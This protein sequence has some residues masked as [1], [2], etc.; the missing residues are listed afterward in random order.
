MK[1]LAVHTD[2]ERCCQSGRC[3]DALPEVFGNDENGFVLLKQPMVMGHLSDKVASCADL[4]PGG[5]IT[6]NTARQD[7]QA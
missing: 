2:R 4:C 5:A 1:Y 3:S 7:S 6:W